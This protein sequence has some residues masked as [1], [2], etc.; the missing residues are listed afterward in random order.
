MLLWGSNIIARNEIAE[1]KNKQQKRFEKIKQLVSVQDN[2]IKNEILSLSLI[3]LRDALQIGKYSAQSVLNAYAWKA[4]NVQEKFNCICEFIIESFDEAKSL[5]QKFENSDDKPPL[6]GIPFSVKE[7]FY[8]KGYNSTIGMV[9]N[10]NNPKKEDC[11]LVTQL[12]NLGAIPFVI[13]NVPQGLLSFVC[14]NPIFGTTGN[15]YNPNRTPGGS[16]GGEACLL[17][18]GGTPFAVGSDIGGS[19]RIPASFCGLY[20]LKPTQDR[21]IVENVNSSCPGISHVALSYGF[22]TNS[23]EEQCFLLNLVF[24][25]LDYKKLILRNAASLPFKHETYNKTIKMKKMR[26]GYFSDDG[27]LKPV[28]A[29]ARVVLETKEKLEA[30]GY[31]LVKFN[32]PNPKKIASCTFK[33]LIPDNGVYI[34]N[35]YTKNIIDNHLKQ[36]IF[37][38]RVPTFLKS[39]VGYLIKL[40]SPQLSIMAHSYCK[41]S[42]DVRINFEE[43]DNYVKEFTSLWKELMLDGLICPSF[44]I[45]AIPHQ[46]CSQVAM[47]AFSTAIFNVLDYCS[48]IVPVDK[49]TQQDDLDLADETKW[50]T[51]YNICY[52]LIRKAANN[53]EGL[54]IA[55]QVVT[56]PFEEEKCLGIMKTVENV[57]QKLK[58]I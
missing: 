31:E 51:G 55:V 14:S 8:V 39:I 34:V 20:S 21:F 32:V 43:I 36:F 30:A 18:A 40:I 47:C 35:E 5:D 25:T 41:S 50:P 52:K 54:P 53:S 45:P 6:F 27:F 1:T 37:L 10:L 23:I 46:Y 2:D 28:P 9:S 58:I 44:T 17:A 19:L 24:G 11:T 42:S 29:C 16:S 13:T 48:G 3:S 26:I 57:W 33:S 56:L 4:M 38:L 22:F 7:N 49:V 12:R 15:P